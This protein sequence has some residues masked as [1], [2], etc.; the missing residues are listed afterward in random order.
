MTRQTG[1]LSLDRRALLGG[2]AGAFLAPGVRAQRANDVLTFIEGSD[3]D[4]LDPAISRTRSAEILFYLM[5]NRLARWTDTTLSAIGP[6]LAESWTISDDKLNWTFRLRE[7]VRFHDGTAA[8]AEAVKFCIDRLR[9]PAFGSP[10]RSLYTAITAITVLDPRTVRFT[11]A[12]PHAGLLE[13]LAESSAAISSPTA[14]RRYGRNYGRNPV[15]SGPY[16]L[17]EW[18]PGERTVL[19]RAE[20]SARFRQIIYRPVPEGE[21]RLIELEAGTAD[22]A[23]GI[24]PEATAR[25]RANP[26]LKLE[27]I[28]SS[29]QVFFE[30]NCARPPFNDVRVRRAIQSAIDREA[31]VQRILGGFGTVPDSFVAPGVQ[32]YEPIGRHPYD[33]D[34]AKR[35]I[36][37]VFPGGFPEKIVMWTSSGRYLKDQQVAEAVQGYLNA[38]GLQTEFRAWEWASYQQTL[39]RRTPN[40]P[41]TGYGTNAAHMWVLGTSI[42]TADWRLSRRYQTGQSA[43]ILG[44]SE[45]RVDELLNRARVTLDP[46]ARLELYHQANRL[47]WQDN[48]P[49]IPLYNQSQIIAM[50][51]GISNFNAFAFEI[52]LLGEVRKS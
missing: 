9:D 50:Q 34:R 49:N 16:K 15:G 13:N 48:P 26:R 2:A 5:F 46:A 23:T 35:E 22:I 31:I 29:F 11:T 12:Q 41:G 47:L 40:V 7:G 17:E 43:N 45:P 52:P 30:L 32:G 6:D 1:T 38:I 24:P 19:A 42:P 4:T 8:D 21:A 27:V 28:P 3:F 44:Y 20:P 39:Y 25:V 18:A 51:R 10:N 14:I 37:A 36:E 33:P